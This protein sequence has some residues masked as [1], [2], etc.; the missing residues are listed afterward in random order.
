MVAISVQVTAIIHAL[1]VVARAALMGQLC[2]LN[3][4]ISSLNLDCSNFILGLVK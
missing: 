1:A 3:D 2:T 4:S